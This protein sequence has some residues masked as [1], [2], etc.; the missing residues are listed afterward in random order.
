MKPEMKLSIL[1]PAYNEAES[2]SGVLSRFTGYCQARGID[3]EIIV[4]N[5]GS[6]D[7]TAEKIK[8]CMSS[9]PSVR[10]IEY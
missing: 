8:E 3:H 5:D 9:R 6:S 4:V 1:F 10:L 7:A 2:I